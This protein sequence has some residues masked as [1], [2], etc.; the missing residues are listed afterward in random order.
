[1]GLLHT[2]FESGAMFTAGSDYGTTG[3]S[4][5]N[6]ITNRINT[7]MPELNLISGTDIV[8]HASGNSSFNKTSYLS[9][10]PAEFTTLFPDV[11]DVTQMTAYMSCNSQLINTIAPVNL[12][13]GAIVTEAIVY[14][15]PSGAQA[16]NWFLTKS[17]HTG[18]YNVMGGAGI[19]SADSSI[20]SSIIDNVN[21]SYSIYIGTLDPTSAIYGATITYTTKYD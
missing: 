15:N 12:P 21:A 14:G 2:S 6:E 10:N 19:G 16:V 4:G 8:I 13:H 17:G 3:T 11:D 1:M 7:I 9:I 5:I 18:A 20:D